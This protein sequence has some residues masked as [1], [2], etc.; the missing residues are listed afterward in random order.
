MTKPDNESV[1]ELRGMSFLEFLRR[2]ASPLTFL[3]GAIAIVTFMGAREIAYAESFSDSISPL[4]LTY[5]LTR[6]HGAIDNSYAGALEDQREFWELYKAALADLS[7]RKKDPSHFRTSMVRLFRC[8]AETRIDQLL[9]DTSSVSDDNAREAIAHGLVVMR[10]IQDDF[11]RHNKSSTPFS[12]EFSSQLLSQ[13]RTELAE[14]QRAVESLRA[15]RGREPSAGRVHLAQTVCEQSRR[16]WM[17]IFLA[18]TDPTTLQGLPTT[19]VDLQKEAW[20]LTE[21]LVKEQESLEVETREK[22]DEY[23]RSNHHRWASA[24]ALLVGNSRSMADGIVEKAVE[25]ERMQSV[26]NRAE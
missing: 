11:A 1:Q 2:Y 12:L 4:S 5:S 14:F 10:G 25:K 21:S 15:A 26:S 9:N 8:D 6:E 13:H 17:V 24:H 20:E 3:S 19:Y 16:T 18:S 7:S 22:L 23:R